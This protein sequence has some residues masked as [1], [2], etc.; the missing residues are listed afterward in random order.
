MEKKKTG[1]KEGKNPPKKVAFLRTL[2]YWLKIPET[3]YPPPTQQI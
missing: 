1:R 3:K 2:S